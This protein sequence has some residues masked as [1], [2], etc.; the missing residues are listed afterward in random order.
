MLERLLDM[1]AEGGI[2]TP[3]QLAD[4]LGVSQGLMEHMLADLSRMGYL[5]PVNGLSCHAPAGAESIPCSG[6]PVSS[7]CA[8]GQPGGQVWAL[9]NKRPAALGAPPMV[10]S[11]KPQ[12]AHRIRAALHWLRR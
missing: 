2:R 8:V 6:C 3:T 9:T 12:P 10:D 11:D 7:A 5:R 1:L 4:Q